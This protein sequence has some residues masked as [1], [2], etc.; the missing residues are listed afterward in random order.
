MLECSSMTSTIS[1]PSTLRSGMR[2]SSTMTVSLMRLG[3]RGGGMSRTIRSCRITRSLLG[4]LLVISVRRLRLV[5]LL[6]LRRRTTTS[7]SFSVVA[8]MKPEP[9]LATHSSQIKRRKPATLPRTMPAT[10]PG[11]GPELRPS[12]WAGIAITT[13]LAFCR[14]RSERLTWSTAWMTVRA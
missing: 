14:G 5:P 11:A 9:L 3:S 7:S 4:D 12:Y 6:R 1:S 8:R 13:P 2:P 10:A